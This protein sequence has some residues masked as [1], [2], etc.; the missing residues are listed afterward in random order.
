MVGFVFANP[1]FDTDGDGQFDGLPNFNFDASV[2]GIIGDG[3]VGVGYNWWSG[4]AGV[5][6]TLGTSLDYNL[7]DSGVDF[8]V[9][10]GFGF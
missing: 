8:R 1:D 6:T 7:T 4:G 9:N 5:K 3:T 2:T 10:V